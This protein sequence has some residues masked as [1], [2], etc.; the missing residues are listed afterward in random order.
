M[1]TAPPGAASVSAIPSDLLGHST[2]ADAEGVQ[3]VSGIPTMATYEMLSRLPKLDDDDEVGVEK[4]H[5]VPVDGSPDLRFQ[6]TLLA[7]TAP[8]T[9]TGD[10]WREYRVYRTCGGNYV[11]SKIGR[12]LLEN[13]RDIFE[14]LVW[15]PSKDQVAE[16]DER[17]NSTVLKGY[18]SK[19]LA[20]AAAEYF[21]FDA[22]AKQL[23]AKLDLDVS[24][25]VE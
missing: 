15:K 9:I 1:R 16:Y 10:R 2:R 4:E 11:F 19:E 6:G 3:F 20:E 8:K 24:R 18:R 25:R 13:E 14:A 23:Y 5:V 22:M 12:S 21:K 17:A 7:S